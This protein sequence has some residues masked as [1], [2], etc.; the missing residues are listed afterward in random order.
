MS[1]LDSMTRVYPERSIFI[2]VRKNTINLSKAAYEGLSKP[3]VVEIYVG[4]G[5]AALK[6]GDGFIF[7]TV[8]P[9]KQNLYRISGVNMVRQVKEQVG[10]GRISALPSASVFTASPLRPIRLGWLSPLKR[11]SMRFSIRVQPQ[12]MLNMMLKSQVQHH[13]MLKNRR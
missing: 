3:D 4:G 1:I 11:L 9:G 8:E 2:V 13:L 5:K 7:A 12:M 6:P 10:E